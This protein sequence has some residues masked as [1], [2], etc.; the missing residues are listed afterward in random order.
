[1]LSIK[2]LL[3]ARTLTTFQQLDKHIAKL[4]K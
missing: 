4:I 3:S 1:L 2:S